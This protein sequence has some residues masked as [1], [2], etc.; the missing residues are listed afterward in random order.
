[1]SAVDICPIQ[2]STCPSSIRYEICFGMDRADAVA[3]EDITTN[4]KA[5]GTTLW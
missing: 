2:R 4:V 5:V 1:M 3:V